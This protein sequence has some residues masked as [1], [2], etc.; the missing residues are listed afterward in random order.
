M[1]SH[2]TADVSRQGKMC[3]GRTSRDTFKDG[4]R[5]AKEILIGDAA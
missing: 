5:I 1:I 4:I 3:C 2:V